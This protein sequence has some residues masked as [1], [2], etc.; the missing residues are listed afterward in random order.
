[1]MLHDVELK[2]DFSETRVQHEIQ[3][4]ASLGTS[5]IFGSA[6]ICA[7]GGAAVKF[8]E[9]IGAWN[10]EGVKMAAAPG[11]VSCCSSF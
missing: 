2:L 10:P 7:G 11:L 3:E 1:M 6:S 8:V 5:K 9:T 4:M